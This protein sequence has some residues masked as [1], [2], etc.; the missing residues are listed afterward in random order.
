MRPGKKMV[1]EQL[2]LEV[3]VNIYVNKEYGDTLRKDIYYKRLKEDKKMVE[4]AANGGSNAN[5][6][7]EGIGPTVQRVY[8]VTIRL[9]LAG[10]LTPMKLPFPK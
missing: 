6:N 10:Q 3:D 2:N 7:P 5:P 9:Y 1:K 4:S 8:P